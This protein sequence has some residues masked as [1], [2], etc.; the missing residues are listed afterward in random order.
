MNGNLILLIKIIFLICK[1]EFDL[2][3]SKN[4]NFVLALII[5]FILYL[6]MIIILVGIEIV[7]KQKKFH[8]L[9]IAFIIINI[10]IQP[11]LVKNGFS[12]LDCVELYENKKFLASADLTIE[13][14]SQEYYQLVNIHYY[15][16]FNFK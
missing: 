14:Y 10:S 15:H 5:P 16:I 6:F 13:C 1:L 8:R 12:G 11:Y 3:F 9:L 4:F 2:N 7:K